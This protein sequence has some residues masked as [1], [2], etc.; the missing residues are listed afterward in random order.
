VSIKGSS[1]ANFKRALD[2]KNLALIRGAAAELSTIN[3]EDSLQIALL[4]CEQEHEHAERASLRW[5]G[6]SCLE[7]REVTLAQVR[8][9]LEAFAL[10]VENPDSAEKATLRR[11]VER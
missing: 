7:R 4:V 9:A 10:L 1:Y 6:R 2:T 3:L 8:E 11:L 5:L